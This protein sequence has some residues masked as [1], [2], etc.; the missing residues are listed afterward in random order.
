LDSSCT[1]GGSRIDLTQPAKSQLAQAFK[2]AV[3]VVRSASPP[4]RLTTNERLGRQ[5]SESTLIRT[6]AERQSSKEPRDG[7]SR[8]VTP[9]WVSQPLNPGDSQPLRVTTLADA[10]APETRRSTA[11]TRSSSLLE[12]RSAAE[13]SM[14]RTLKDLAPSWASPGVVHRPVRSSAGAPQSGQCG[15]G[16]LQLPM[17]PNR[18]ESR[19]LTSSPSARLGLA[20][21]S[22]S[23]E[24]TAGVT[25]GDAEQVLT[26]INALREEVLRLHED[27]DSKDKVSD[28]QKSTESARRSVTNSQATISTLR[29][30]NGAPASRSS[31]A[32]PCPCDGTLSSTTSTTA[33]SGA[34][35]CGSGAPSAA[36]GVSTSS[37]RTICG[38]ASGVSSIQGSSFNSPGPPGVSS[39]PSN[40]G[41]RGPSPNSMVSSSHP[42]ARP[43]TSPWQVRP[44]L[45]HGMR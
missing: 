29:S 20:G 17:E 41:L 26:A 1:D 25:T 28:A 42:L 3:A 21:N 30:A 13:A 45:P 11:V 22:Q 12:S 24:D 14:Q 27:K 9:G 40:A 8:A 37:S 44:P 6:A 31:P 10:V 23:T 16:S 7:L 4:R 36:G 32:A 39:V 34:Y 43:S 19:G 15:C 33:T 35:G 5:S 2:E 38:G 18:L